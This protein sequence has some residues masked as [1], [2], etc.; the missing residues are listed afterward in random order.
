M[1]VPGKVY[2]WGFIGIC[3]H[4]HHR[5]GG[6]QNSRFPG[7]TQVVGINHIVLQ[8]GTKSH[9]YQEIR[10][11]EILPSKFPDVSQRQTLQGHLRIASRAWLQILGNPLISQWK[12]TFSQVFRLIWIHKVLGNSKTYS[13]LHIHVQSLLKVIHWFEKQ[14]FFSLIRHFMKTLN[15]S[16]HLQ[17]HC[18]GYGQRTHNEFFSIAEP[19][20]FEIE[21]FW[22]LCPEI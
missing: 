17:R 21:H 16:V 13:T 22:N 1:S 15:F 2:A 11:K 6:Y 9:S 4:R 7:R 18:P 5:P 20:G 19:R 10:E 14:F 3:S 8:L 12:F